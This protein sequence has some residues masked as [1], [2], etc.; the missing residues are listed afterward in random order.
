MN[1]INYNIYINRNNHIISEEV[2]NETET[3]Y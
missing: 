3:N 2:V 1:C